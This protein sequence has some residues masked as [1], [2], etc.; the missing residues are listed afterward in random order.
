[1]TSRQL[2]GGYWLAFLF[3]RSKLWLCVMAHD[4]GRLERRYLVWNGA[5]SKK[6]IIMVNV[7]SIKKSL[8]WLMLLALW[9]LTLLVSINTFLLFYKW[10][11]KIDSLLYG[12]V[13]SVYAI[14]PAQVLYLFW[15]CCW[16][17]SSTVRLQKQLHGLSHRCVNFLKAL[18]FF[19]FHWEHNVT[20]SSS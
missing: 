4:R 7:V 12:K 1:M 18:F 8:S 17:A 6:V 3:L 11:F 20:F 13:N 2:R 15:S 14:Q 5:G 19:L 10:C 9:S 16:Q